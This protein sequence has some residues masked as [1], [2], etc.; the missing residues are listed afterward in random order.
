MN[1]PGDDVPAYQRFLSSRFVDATLWVVVAISVVQLLWRLLADGKLWLGP[2]L[3][4]VMA[5]A[6]LILRVRRRRV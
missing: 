5:A 4:L 3:I 1:T 2:L 6:S